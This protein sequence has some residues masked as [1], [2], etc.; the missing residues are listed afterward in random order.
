MNKNAPTEC[1]CGKRHKMH[2][3]GLRFVCPAKI[4]NQYTLEEHVNSYP[5]YAATPKLLTAL[6]DPMI[7]Y[8]LGYIAEFS[9]DGGDHTEK[10]GSNARKAK[11]RIENL[12]REFGE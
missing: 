4:T 11:R 2:L 8:A 7:T 10:D 6:R 5:V 1:P 3:N 9:G 12:L